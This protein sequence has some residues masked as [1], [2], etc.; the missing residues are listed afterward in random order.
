VIALSVLH[1]PPH[2]GSTSATG[3]YRLADQVYAGA[4]SKSIVAKPS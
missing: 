2:P 3:R 4:R 1:T